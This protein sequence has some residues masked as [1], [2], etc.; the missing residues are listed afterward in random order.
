MGL[1]P[2]AGGPP[3]WLAGMAGMA[4]QVLVVRELL[5]AFQG[6]ELTLGLVLAAWVALEAVGIGAGRRFSGG[7]DLPTWYSRFYVLGLIAIPVSFYLGRLSRTLLGVPAGQA[8]GAGEMAVAALLA[9]GPAALTHGLLFASACRVAGSRGEGG[10]GPARVYIQET[11]GTLVGAV[12]VTVF[13]ALGWRAS[14]ILGAVLVAAGLGCLRTRGGEER[15]PVTRGRWAA[16]AALVLVLATG[17]PVLDRV[18]GW[19]IRRQWSGQDVV[20]HADSPHGNTAVVRTGRQ[21]AVHYGGLLAATVPVPDVELQEILAHLPLVFHPVPDA[22]LILAGGAGGLLAEL[23]EHPVRRITYVE[24]DPVFLQAML[25]TAAPCVTAELGDARLQVLYG[26]ARRYLRLTPERYDVVILGAGLPGTLQVNRLYTRESF[27][28]VSRALAPGGIFAL[29]A[30]GHRAYL[31]PELLQ[32]LQCL[33][34]TLKDAFAHV[35]VLP[36]DRVLFLAGD[37]PGLVQ[38]TGADLAGRWRERDREADMVSEAYLKYRLNPL[39]WRRAEAEIA[40]G[41][42]ARPNTDLHPVGVFHSLRYWGAMFTPGLARLLGAAGGLSL[43]WILA[44]PLLVW[45][46]GRLALRSPRRRVLGAVFTTGMVGMVGDV[47]LILALQSIHG[48]VYQLVGI[49]LAAFMGGAA[50]GAHWAAGRPAR[51][52]GRLFRRLEWAMVAFALLVVPGLWLA[53]AIEPAAGALPAVF[54]LTCAT[55][56]LAVGAQFTLGLAWLAGEGDPARL[57]GKLYGADLAGG[58]LGGVLAGTVLLPVLGFPGT[59]LLLAAIKLGSASILAGG[60]A[61]LPPEPAGR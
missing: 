27:Q 41:H 7:G 43:G 30:P 10:Q 48:H 5:V 33:Y 61:V 23:Q 34:T 51:V 29:A 18:D 26:D 28:L 36:G 32:L 4:A 17:L 14:S 38:V 55:L 35:R 46:M 52:A 54:A 2:R 31:G 40:G 56:G 12:A 3:V 9:T 11:A 20:F 50:A 6:N 1:E 15:G 42:P 49:L 47:L 22:V 44:V 37:D 8:L 16:I 60:G 58:C 19:S 57:A 59:A 13:L 45:V 53:R 39:L 25:A 21:Y 24:L